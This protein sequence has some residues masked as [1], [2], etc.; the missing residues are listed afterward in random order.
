MTLLE[1]GTTKKR[2][3]TYIRYVRI[4]AKFVVRLAI[5]AALYVHVQKLFF[6]KLTQLATFTKDYLINTL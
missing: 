5:V 2:R 4:G 1:L 6:S 3:K